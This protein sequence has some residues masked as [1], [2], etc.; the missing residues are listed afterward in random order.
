MSFVK[1]IDKK[2]V[3]K[4][5]MAFSF[6]KPAGFSFKAGQHTDWTL[7]NPPE[8][9]AE[10]DSRTF[11]FACAPSEDFLMIAS[12]MRDT[13]FKRVLK[14]MALGT[15]IQVGDPV[16]SLTLPAD[17]ARPLVLLAGGIG[18]TPFRSI[19]VEAAKKTL[20]HKIFLV[21][22]NRLPEDAPFLEELE[23]IANPNYQLF[24]VFTQETGHLTSQTLAK[25][26]TDFKTPIYFLA[27]PPRMVLAM[28]EILVS[29][30]VD[31]LSIRAE[32]FEG[33]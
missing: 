2:E 28:R 27:G 32:E 13:A 4:D 31:D 9:D 10:G 26:I 5:T 18:I 29:A 12:R 7:I 8:T 30:G 23:K 14:N 17:P 11:S 22:S 20:P 16:G 3:A 6:A 15:E 25:F 33:Y 19:V 24:N 1:L 21:C